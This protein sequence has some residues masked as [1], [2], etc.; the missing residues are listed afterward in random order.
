MNSISTQ[1]PRMRSHDRAMPSSNDLPHDGGNPIDLRA[2]W[3]AVYR[4]RLKLVVT[5]VVALLIGLLITF[6]S[7]PIFRAEARI[8][9]EQQSAEILAG[10]DVEPTSD[11]ILDGD[12]FLQTQIDII[13]SRTL[14]RQVAENLGLYRSNDFLEKMRIKP[15][16]EPRGAYNLQQTHREQ[17]VD[18]LQKN[19]D[20]ELP[21]ESRIAVISFD[22]PDR[23]LLSLIHI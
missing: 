8:Q 19:M 4:N 17:I 12:R 10:N 2:V 6:L 7:T 16:T 11:S 5:L 3:S 22:S 20:V 15:A 23:Q 21:V 9:I 14:A 18:A 13:K 1:N